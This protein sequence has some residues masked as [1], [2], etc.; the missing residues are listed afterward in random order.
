MIQNVFVEQKK[1]ASVVKIQARIRGFLAR[2]KV[3]TLISEPEKPITKTK[4][5]LC[6]EAFRDL[7]KTEEEY[8][9]VLDTIVSVRRIVSTS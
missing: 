7:A 2:K 1:L 6:L 4:M 9:K 5:Y 3:K 8:I